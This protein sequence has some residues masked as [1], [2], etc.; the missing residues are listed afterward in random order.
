MFVCFV[1]ELLCAVVWCILV[2]VR[3]FVR[4]MC[5]RVLRDVLCDTVGC[6]FVVDFMCVGVLILCLLDVFMMY[7]VLF[8]GLCLCCFVVM[9]VGFD[10]FVRVVCDLL[11]EDV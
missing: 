2:V 9:R 10:V 11:C 5:L 1:C 6:V 7:C 4:F 3:A 8:S